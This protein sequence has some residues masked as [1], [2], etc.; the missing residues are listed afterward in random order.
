MNKE[1]FWEIIDSV[2]QTSAGQ[3]RETCLAQVQ[4]KLV[5]GTL[6]DIMD[7]YLIFQE[8]HEAAYRYEL[9]AAS[10]ALGAHYTDDG[11]IDFRSW[12]ISRGKRVYMDAMQDPDSLA[13]VPRKG[14]DLNFESFGYLAHGAYDI[15]LH[16]IDPMDKTDLFHALAAHTLNS[17]TAESIRAELPQRPDIDS[18][19]R[20]WMLPDLFPNICKRREPKDIK[21][22]LAAGELVYASVYKDG[23]CTEYAFQYTAK[24][25]AN[26]LGSQPDAKT[27]V[28]TD[29]IDR[30]ILNT[31]RNLID[32]C[33]DKVLLEYIKRTLIPIQTGQ[34]QA[35]PFFCPRRHSVEN[36]CRRH[37]ILLW[38]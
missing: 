10:A 24:N 18:G 9:W 7:W 16:A 29:V 14:E 15:K 5:E 25:I 27:I 19:W 36:Y 6:K 12:L 20:G 30:L 11:F 31:A 1:Q 4:N 22:M 23:K 28:I 17:E 8:Y 2:N 37:H 3:A 13:A 34:A 21:G 33:P 38:P 26:F 32:R 35:Q